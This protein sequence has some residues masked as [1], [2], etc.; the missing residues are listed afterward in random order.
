MNII[1]DCTQFAIRHRGKH[2]TSGP[3]WS[4]II[5]FVRLY[6]YACNL[7]AALRAIADQAGTSKNAD[8]ARRRAIEALKEEVEG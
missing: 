2:K 3:H 4:L 7:Q 8:S 1:E 6:D 5:R